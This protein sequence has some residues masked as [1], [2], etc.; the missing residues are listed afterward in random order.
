MSATAAA[1]TSEQHMTCND[2][3][4]AKV[5]K[6]CA[7]EHLAVRAQHA[8]LPGVYAY[9]NVASWLFLNT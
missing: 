8:V 9:T 3:I 5:T 6:E 2:N 1:M 4:H 7:D